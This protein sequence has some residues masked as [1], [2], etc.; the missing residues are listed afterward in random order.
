MSK[1]E[2]VNFNNQERWQFPNIEQS[3]IDTLANKYDLAPLL[4]KLLISRKIQDQEH[5]EIDDFLNP[6][7]EL[8]KEFKGISVDSELEKAL[9]RLTLA[10]KNKEKVLINGDPDADGITGTSV[11]VIG[12]RELGYNVDFDFPTRATEGHGLHPRIIDDAK[13]DGVSLVL[14]ID[15]GTREVKS[16]EYAN[17]QGIDVI[18]CDHT[19][20]EK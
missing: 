4:A 12:L 5:I 11:L 6:P 10:K 17:Q 15:C 1:V 19:E 13:K 20:L 16:I 7:F 2:Q 3:N 9:K 8:L 14:T 18:V